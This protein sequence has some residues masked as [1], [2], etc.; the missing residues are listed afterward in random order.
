MSWFK[1]IICYYC[2]KKNYQIE[3]P[4]RLLTVGQICNFIFVLLLVG[5]QVGHNWNQ[6]YSMAINN[7]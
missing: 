1:L 3:S 6:I 5:A 4:R 7:M 2:D